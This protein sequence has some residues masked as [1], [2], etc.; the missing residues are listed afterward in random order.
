[1]IE[2]YIQAKILRGMQVS[3]TQK[4][5][6]YTFEK[7]IVLLILLNKISHLQ[8]SCLSYLKLLKKK[9]KKQKTKKTNI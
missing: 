1:M 4:G 5:A 6:G 9:N 7:D 2:K 3:L 8:F